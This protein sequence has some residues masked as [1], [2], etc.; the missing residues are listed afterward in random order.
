M[1]LRNP[2]PL[3]NGSPRIHTAKGDLTGR[4]VIDFEMVEG[5]KFYL[6]IRS[7]DPGRIGFKYVR[8]E[9]LPGEENEC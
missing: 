1:N 3:V 5:F 9:Q 2:E 7:G 6:L 4:Y 8:L